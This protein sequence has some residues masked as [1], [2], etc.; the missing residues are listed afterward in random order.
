MIVVDGD[1]LLR[2]ITTP[3]QYGWWDSVVDWAEDWIILL[4][5]SFHW[6]W[7]PVADSKA[8]ET[9][10]RCGWSVVMSCVC[11]SATHSL[12][13]VRN[14]FS[15]LFCDNKYHSFSL[16]FLLLLDSTSFLVKWTNNS[17]QPQLLEIVS[18]IAVN[19]SPSFSDCDCYWLQAKGRPP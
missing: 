18:P 10:Y 12:I 15:V 3:N 19:S 14:K 16:S 17:R 4:L 8:N 13:C 2:L 7:L 9:E 1:A 11:C 6:E 5:S